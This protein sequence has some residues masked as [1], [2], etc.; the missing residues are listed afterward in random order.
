MTSLTVAYDSRCGLCCAVAAW[1]RRQPQLV[2]VICVPAHE[3]TDELTVT[4]D[5]G[6]CWSGDD[7]WVM[8]LWAL[9]THRHTAYRLANPSLRPTA[10]A[11]FK[12]LS[13]YRGSLS[14]ALNLPAEA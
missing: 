9:S 13:A 2:P 12:K 14:C 11:L 8:V 7:A 5:S 10:R 6:D 4:A 1:V 3:T